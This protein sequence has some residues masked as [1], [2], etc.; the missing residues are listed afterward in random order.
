MLLL[1]CNTSK[2]L[3]SIEHLRPGTAAGNMSKA[4]A[5]LKGKP[6]PLAFAAR[7]LLIQEPS[8]TLALK[9][10]LF[11]DIQIVNSGKNPCAY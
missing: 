11:P 1:Y 3:S 9:H 2:A 7:R 10:S 5:Y 4:A 6:I 8:K